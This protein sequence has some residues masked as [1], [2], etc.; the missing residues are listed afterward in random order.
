MTSSQMAQGSHASTVH[1]VPHSN[2][3]Q[4][5]SINPSLSAV[6]KQS[7]HTTAQANRAQGSNVV[8]SDGLG[9]SGSGHR[10]GE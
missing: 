2:A 6:S 10:H 8:P 5:Q 3:S 1:G 9:R 4:S 7:H